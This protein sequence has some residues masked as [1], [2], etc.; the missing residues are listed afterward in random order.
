[1]LQ[2]WIITKYTFAVWTKPLQEELHSVVA[3]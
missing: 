1:M 2:K 3:S